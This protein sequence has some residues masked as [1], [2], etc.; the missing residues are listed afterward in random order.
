MLHILTPRFTLDP[1]HRL[2]RRHSTYLKLYLFHIST[3]KVGIFRLDGVVD[4]SPKPTYMIWAFFHVPNSIL[5]Q[6]YF[7][8]KL[9]GLCGNIGVLCM[10]GSVWN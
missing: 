8:C 9:I 6:E 3:L 5:V 1:K 2:R 7:I 10:T 4:L